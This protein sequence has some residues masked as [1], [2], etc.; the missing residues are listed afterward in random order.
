MTNSTSDSHTTPLPHLLSPTRKKKPT[1]KNNVKIQTKKNNNH[2]KTSPL[3]PHKKQTKG[4][5]EKT[6]TNTQENEKNSKKKEKTITPQPPKKAKTHPFPLPLPPHHHHH[7]PPQPPAETLRKLVQSCILEAS[8]GHVLT[9]SPLGTQHETKSN[10]MA[11][12]KKKW[13]KPKWRR[14]WSRM[15]AVSRG[16][17]FAHSMVSI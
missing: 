10:T 1:Q 7:H 11:A 4:N 8:C 9:E 12:F 13:L 14:R 6:Q 15:L 3:P 5:Q 2:K 16:R 17:A